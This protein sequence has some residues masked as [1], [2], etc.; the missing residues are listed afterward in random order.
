[1]QRACNG[2]RWWRLLGTASLPILLLPGRV[3]AQVD[4][5]PPAAP[6]PPLTSAPRLLDPIVVTAT[7]T[8]E[9][10]FDLPVA[11]DSV[12]AAQIQQNQLQIN[13][14]ESLARVPGIVV[15]SRWNYAQDV[16]VSIRGFGAR[17]NF[18]VRGI[19]LYQDGIP[20]TMPDGQGQTSSFSLVSAKRIEVMRGPFST[21]YGNAAGGVI[22]IFTEDGPDP[23][24][25]QAQVVGG[26]YGTWNSIVKLEGATPTANYVVA[27]NAFQ[28]DGYREHSV[29]TRDLGNV[30]LRFDLGEDTKLTVIGNSFYQPDAQDPLGLTRAEWQADPRQADPAATLFNTRKTVNQQQGGATLEQRLSA[31]TTLRVIGYGGT[32]LVRQY[33]ALTGIGLTSSGG[34]TDLSGDFWGVDA[35]ATTRSPFAGGSLLLTAGVA[36]DEQHQLRKGFVNNNGALSD[37]RRDEDDYVTDNDAYIQAEWS[38]ASVS[39]LAGLRYSDVRFKSKDHY[40]NTV[41]PDDSGNVSYSH[42]S[43][44][45]GAVWHA[46][47]DLNVYA[48][49]GVGFETPSFIELAYRPVGTGLNFALQPAI[50][51]SAELGVKARLQQQRLNVSVFSINTTDDLVIDTATGGRTTYTNAAKTRRRGLEAEWEAALGNGFT[52]YASYTYLLAQFAAAATTGTPPQLIPEGARLPGL[53]GSSAYAELSWSRP[54]WYGFSAALE[55]QYANKV[56]VNDRNTDF[57]PAYAVA[58]IRAGFQQGAGAWT[59]T[60]FVRIN[61]LAGRNYSGTVIVG[62]TNGRYFEPSA[63]RNFLVGVTVNARF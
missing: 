6:V 27:A 42:P 18:G 26:S 32:R 45:V 63:E 60:E 31:D 7:R 21:L 15:Q 37:L 55:G 13:L 36:Y 3:A 58:N 29:A 10:A 30:K 47:D 33:L 38:L 25:A 34:V 61:N 54:D 16:M 53:P 41:N 39:F 50:S 59:F 28:T 35:R 5:G 8:E 22:A 14:S 1:M 44:V 12:D 4:A 46:T 48:N 51:K 20:A 40:I 2:S 62:D 43:P 56:Y 52:A 19:R 24:M 11:I 57:A 9:R 17:A 49:W 23:P